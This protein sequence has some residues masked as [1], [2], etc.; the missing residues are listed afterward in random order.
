MKKLI[1][2]S[3]LILSS[4]NINHANE[5]KCFIWK[6]DFGNA[7]N[8]RVRTLQSEVRYH[9]AEYNRATKSKMEYRDV[10]LMRNAAQNVRF[11]KQNELGILKNKHLTKAN[12]GPQFQIKKYNCPN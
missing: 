10:L 5:T 3:L 6:D 2:T 7:Q 1:I 11:Q 8:H 4:F 9:E 12:S